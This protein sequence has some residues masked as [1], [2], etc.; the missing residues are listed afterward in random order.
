MNIKEI[1]KIANVSVATI[2]RVVNNDP[3]VKQTTREKVE[4]V[5]KQFNYTPN[6]YATRLSKGVTDKIVGLVVP[7]V[8]NIL[9][10][11]M[12]EVISNCAEKENITILLCNTSGEYEKEKKFT[13]I[14]IDYKVKGVIYIP[15]KYESNKNYT[16]LKEVSLN[17]IPIVFLD[18]E[19]KGFDFDGV[20]LDNQNISYNI[21]KEILKTAPKKIYFISGSLDI[22][23]AHE[24]FLGFKK[25][26]DELN[27][28]NEEYE[29]KYGDF[30]F[31]SGY[32]LGEDILK[33]DKNE[34][35]TI[36]IANN[37]MALGFLKVLKKHSKKFKRISIA[38]F[39]ISDI[40][41]MLLD[42][43]NYITCKL[44]NKEIAEKSFELLIDKINNPNT[45]YEKRKKILCNTTIINRINQKS[46]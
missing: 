12:I 23:S 34:E 38:I 5:M 10:S 3:K 45:C 35:L 2:S 33:N 41:D 30:K 40:L 36:Y 39:G 11:E 42:E 22:S 37:T 7:D 27:I 26:V 18:R 9:F 16:H 19:V 4:Q 15:G 8:G 24:R 43:E 6:S 17:N 1:A 31:E 14:L 29:I 44:P 20:F 25:A 13:K 28:S 21:T 46:F 32:R